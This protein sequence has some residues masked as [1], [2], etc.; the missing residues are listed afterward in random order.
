MKKLIGRVIAVECSQLISRMAKV[1]K[2]HSASIQL[3]RDQITEL[4]PLKHL[5]VQSSH[6]DEMYVKIYDVV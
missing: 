2:Q 6:P 4:E 3:F 1:R 5:T